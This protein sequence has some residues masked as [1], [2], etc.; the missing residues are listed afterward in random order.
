MKMG[1][2]MQLQKLCSLTNRTLLSTPV[3]EI[4]NYP[5]IEMRE[6]NFDFLRFILAFTV[7]IGHLIIVSGI[8]DFQKY[9][10]FISSYTSVTA[11]FIISGFLITNSFK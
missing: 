5:N 3:T 6:N 7:V 9:L 11:F 8:D 1:H 2:K 10:R 4:N